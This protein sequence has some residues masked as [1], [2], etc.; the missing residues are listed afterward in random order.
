MERAKEQRIEREFEAS[1]VG[2]LRRWLALNDTDERREF[3]GDGGLGR[4]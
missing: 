1:S 4:G 3:E 2:D